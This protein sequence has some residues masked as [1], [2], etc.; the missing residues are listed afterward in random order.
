MTEYKTTIGDYLAALNFTILDHA[1]VTNV[2]PT[3]P[4]PQKWREA[5]N[6]S[7]QGNQQILEFIRPNGDVVILLIQPNE[8]TQKLGRRGYGLSDEE[9][10]SPAVGN[11][12]VLSDF[13]GVNSLEIICPPG[14]YPRTLEEALAAIGHLPHPTFDNPFSE[15]AS[16]TPSYFTNPS[17]LKSQIQPFAPYPQIA[18]CT[19]SGAE[20]NEVAPLHEAGATP[21]DAWV[22]KKPQ[23]EPMK[24]AKRAPEN[25]YDKYWQMNTDSWEKDLIQQF[26]EKTSALD[27]VNEALSKIR[28]YEVNMKELKARVPA[29]RVLHSDRRMHLATVPHLYPQV[30]TTLEQTSSREKAPKP[31]EVEEVRDEAS[32]PGGG[33]KKGSPVDG[34]KFST[35]WI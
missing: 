32:L 33:D 35:T 27:I 22:G 13:S 23:E 19:L 25:V 9:P 34:R 4:I 8:G 15:K 6:R 1:V 20:L 30:D 17:A 14:P 5:F 2:T 16:P 10:G 28:G 29:E 26:E 18:K 31:V 7:I 24:V 12:N 3:S 11:G 21:K